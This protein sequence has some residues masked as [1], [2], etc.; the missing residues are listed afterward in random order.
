MNLIIS[1][2]T[3]TAQLVGQ[4]VST[5]HFGPFTILD[6]DQAP[7]MNAVS[8]SARDADVGYVFVAFMPW[9]TTLTSEPDSTR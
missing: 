4:T 9:G 5:E 1:P 8:Y 2:D 7:E 3:D 6:A